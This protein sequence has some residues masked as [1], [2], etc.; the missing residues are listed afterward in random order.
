VDVLR[1]EE[2]FGFEAFEGDAERVIIEQ[3]TAEDAP[4]RFQ[5]VGKRSFDRGRVVRCAVCG[6]WQEGTHRSS[7][8]FGSPN[9]VLNRR[10]GDESS[11]SDF[12]RLDL[13]RR[14]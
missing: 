6:H 12:Y 1:Q 5:V 14:N 7:L 9:E 13:T 3:D 2:I 11:F 8:L 10:L 4:L